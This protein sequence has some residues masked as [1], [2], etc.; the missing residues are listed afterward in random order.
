MTVGRPCEFDPKQ[1]LDAA[2]CVF[3]QRG[4][5]ATSL[6]NLLE[7]MDLNK[8][9]FYQ[10]F[11]SKAE[12][13]QRCLETYRDANAD[14]L[15]AALDQS[16]SGLDF[17]KDVF[18]GIADGTNDKM[19]RAGCLLMNAASEFAQRDSKIAMLVARSLERVEDIFY[20]ALCRAQ[21]EGDIPR[22]AD[23]RSLALFLTTNLGGLRAMARAGAN[24]EKIHIVVQVVMRSLK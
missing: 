9:S 3:W 20:A 17:I 16:A 10:A 6:E 12:L 15:R 7:A 19:G 24:P 1:A 11:G 23:A 13:Y 22:T 5:E 18:K 2:M 8:S 4:Y 21:A 14:R